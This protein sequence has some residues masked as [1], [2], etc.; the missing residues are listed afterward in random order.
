MNTRRERGT[1]R[2]R[3]MMRTGRERMTRMRMRAMRELLWEEV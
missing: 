3:R 2:K 1:K